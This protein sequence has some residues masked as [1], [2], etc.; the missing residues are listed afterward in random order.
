MLHIQRTEKLILPSYWPLVNN[1]SMAMLKEVVSL[2][3]PFNLCMDELKILLS[4][5]VKL[6]SYQLDM[7]PLI[8]LVHSQI[9]QIPFLSQ[10]TAQS[11]KS[12]FLCSHSAIKLAYD[13]WAGPHTSATSSTHITLLLWQQQGFCHPLTSPSQPHITT[14]NCFLPRL[15]RQSLTSLHD[16]THVLLSFLTE[17]ID[18]P[19]L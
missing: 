10:S 12:L 18:I 16:N 19:D 14:M 7:N 11:L 17:I 4:V 1:M 13:D 15:M 5:Q 3:N 8:V 9:W 2:K 6:D